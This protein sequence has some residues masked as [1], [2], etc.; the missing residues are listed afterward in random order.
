MAKKSAVDRVIEKLEAERAEIGRAIDRLKVAQGAVT[1]RKR[2][3]EDRIG[4][5]VD[6][7]GA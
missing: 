5:A 3:P 6:R 4:T 2:K 7:A 1:K